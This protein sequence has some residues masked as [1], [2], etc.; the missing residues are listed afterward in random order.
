MPRGFQATAFD[1][2]SRFSHPWIRVELEAAVLLGRVDQPSLIP[3]VLYHD[4]VTSTQ[5]GGAL[6]SE[7]A[8]PGSRFGVGLD[9]GYASGDS[10]PPNPPSHTT[11]NT[12]RFH[13]DYRV[14]QIL[15]REIIGTV[16][17]AVYLRPHARYH[18]IRSAAGTL[19][20]QVA[21][22]GSEAVVPSSAPGQRAPLGVEIDPTLAYASRDGFILA[23]DYGVLFPLAGLDNPQQHLT[24]Q[25]AQIARARIM[26]R[27]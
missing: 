20:A 16:T 8:E 17:N 14:D 18:L 7:I 24:A 6:E 23:F 26:Y 15:F 10:A 21:A 22:L 4:A 27:F 13:P 12:F 19:S 25:P 2:W 5:F 9:A 3:G 1:I 11:L